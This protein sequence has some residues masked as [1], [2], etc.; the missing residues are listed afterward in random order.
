MTGFVLMHE[1]MDECYV[2]QTPCFDDSRGSFTK[3][4]HVS[5]YDQLGFNFQPMETF[6]TISHE[7]VLRGMH[8]QTQEAAHKKL[9]TCISGRV[10]DVVVDVRK[11]S[12]TFNRPFSIVLD[13]GK[14]ISLLI[15]KGYAHGFLSLTDHSVMNYMTSTVHDHKNDKGILWSSIA[16]DWPIDNPILSSRDSSHPHIGDSL[17][18]FS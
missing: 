1:P 7:N 6:Y 15:G 18:E 10:L 11:D 17:C 12:P 9:V 3:L 2:F 14:P 16:Y 8:F 4:F 13:A 5:A